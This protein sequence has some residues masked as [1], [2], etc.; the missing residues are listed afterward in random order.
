V[1]CCGQGGLRDGNARTFRERM[2]ESLRA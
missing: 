2:R 1:S